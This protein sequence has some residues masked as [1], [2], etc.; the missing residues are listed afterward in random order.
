MGIFEDVLQNAKAVVGTV[1]KKAGEVVDLSKLKLAAADLKSEIAQ[2][3]QILGRITFEEMTGSKDY[4]KNKAEIIEKIKELKTQL[5]AV[6]DMIAG[7][8]QK[9]KCQFCGAYNAKGAVFCSSCGEKIVIDT[10]ACEH[11]SPDD[12][13]DFTEDNFADEDLL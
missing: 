3:Y 1:G 10:E 4:S 12:V 5:E 9:V 7:A 8:K 6:N 13:I 2:K 11:M